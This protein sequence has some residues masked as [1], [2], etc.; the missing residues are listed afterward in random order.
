MSV[1]A[2]GRNV[3]PKKLAAKKPSSKSKGNS[4]EYSVR[5]DLWKAGFMC[6]R[7][8]RS[9]Q[10]LSAGA[11]QSGINADLI[12]LPKR[13]AG[14]QSVLVE[15]GGPGKG[16]KSAFNGLRGNDC[17]TINIVCRFIERRKQWT[18]ERVNAPRLYCHHK[19][20]GELLRCHELFRGGII[21]GPNHWAKP[22]GA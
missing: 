15:V 20:L 10:R 6:S 21:V 1:N 14:G 13:K 7:I 12:A 18:H 11:K 16:L 19:T 3:K 8:S 17:D 4:R 5:R 2:R 9:G 22:F